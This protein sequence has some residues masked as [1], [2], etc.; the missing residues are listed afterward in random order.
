MFLFKLGMYP[1]E[2][3]YSPKPPSPINFF[4]SEICDG[5]DLKGGYQKGT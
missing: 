2:V 3:W 1:D 5:T 4:L